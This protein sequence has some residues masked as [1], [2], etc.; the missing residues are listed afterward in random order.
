MILLKSWRSAPTCA[1]W[2]SVVLFLTTAMLFSS[3][4]ISVLW[5]Q[6]VYL[7]QCQFRAFLAAWRLAA[8]I[9]DILGRLAV[10]HWK[11]SYFRYLLANKPHFCCYKPFYRKSNSFYKKPDEWR[12]VSVKFIDPALQGK[13]NNYKPY[14]LYD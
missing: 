7:I 11:W 6:L 4:E 8:Q 2:R 13:V 5:R 9:R 3:K 12:R 1:N 10:I 14:L